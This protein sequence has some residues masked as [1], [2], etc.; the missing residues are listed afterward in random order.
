MSSLNIS[1]IFVFYPA[2]NT[3]KFVVVSALL[4]NL[5]NSKINVI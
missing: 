4:Q 3:I 5:L 2:L 1:S